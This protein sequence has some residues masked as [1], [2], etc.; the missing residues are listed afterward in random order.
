MGSLPDD[1]PER[2]RRF[3]NRYGHREEKR[4]R[5]A[6]M[7]LYH[8]LIWQELENYLPATGRVLDAGAGP[9]RYSLPLAVRGLEVVHLDI[10]PV[11]V[12]LAQA[13]AAVRGLTNITFTTGEI[14]NL[15]YPDLSFDLV[16]CL[17]APLSYTPSPTR[18]VAELA[19]VARGYIVAS[20]VNRNGQLPLGVGLESWLT[21]CLRYTREF[22]QT[23]LWTPPPFLERLPGIRHQVL[24]PLYAFAPEEIAHLFQAAGCRVEKLMAPGSL[25]RLVGSRARRRILKHLALRQEFLSLAADFDSRP[26]ILGLGA[27]PASGLLVVARPDEYYSFFPQHITLTEISGKTPPPPV[28][29]SSEG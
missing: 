22:W 15:P 20:V 25:A 24:P 11:M 9:G 19:R 23:G 3:W 29:A 26:E 16:L 27:A 28:A 17:D 10:S 6:E 8:L 18:A 2:H 4:G 13:R 5:S 21:K 14:E 12:E 7:Q 1:S